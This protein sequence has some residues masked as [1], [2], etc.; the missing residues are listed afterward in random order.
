MWAG[1]VYLQ[2]IAAISGYVIKK[3]R[4]L[5]RRALGGMPNLLTL[6]HVTVIHRGWT[7]EPHKQGINTHVRKISFRPVYNFASDHTH[8]CFGHRWLAGLIRHARIWKHQHMKTIYWEFAFIKK[9]TAKA[10]HGVT[11][12]IQDSKC[13]KGLMRVHGF[14]AGWYFY[15]LK[16]LYKLNW[17]I[18][19]LHKRSNTLSC[20]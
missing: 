11:E 20:F 15:I 2:P 18:T 8:N 19:N 14:I 12:Q 1:Y 16:I 6:Q 13:C 7:G 5:L 4:Y 10:S 17:K 9:K 3:G